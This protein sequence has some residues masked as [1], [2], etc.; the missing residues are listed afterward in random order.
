MTNIPR[1]AAPLLKTP[2][3]TQ[4]A[5]PCERSLLYGSRKL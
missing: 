2:A 5:V 1:K 3:N 4:E